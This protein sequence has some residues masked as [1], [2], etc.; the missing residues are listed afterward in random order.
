M[1]VS[2]D[3]GPRRAEGIAFSA[4]LADPNKNLFHPAIQA[5]K[6]ASDH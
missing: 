4:D 5:N 3:C 2:A 6:N 1:F